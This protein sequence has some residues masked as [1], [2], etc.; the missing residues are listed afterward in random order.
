MSELRELY[1]EVILDHYKKPRNAKKPATANHHAD[2]HNPLCGDKISVYLDVDHNRV[3]EI[4]FEGSGCAISTASAS[5]MTDAVKGKSKEEVEA[6]F[7]KFHELVTGKPDEPAHTEG[8]NKLAVFA[9][10]REFPMRVKCASLAWHTLR[11]AFENRSAPV[12]TE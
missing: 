8:L 12:T 9:G 1:Q 7:H 4:G 6:L 2:G 5:L 10:V 3:K 11:A